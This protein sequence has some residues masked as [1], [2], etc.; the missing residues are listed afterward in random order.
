MPLVQ[1]VEQNEKH[2]VYKCCKWEGP[3]HLLSQLP[4][5]L[6]GDSKPLALVSFPPSASHKE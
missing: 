2:T 5:T 6:G 3:I 4:S 1:L